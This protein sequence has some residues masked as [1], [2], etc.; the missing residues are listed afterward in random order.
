MDTIAD[1]LVYQVIFFN[2]L[3]F[4]N[5]SILLDIFNLVPMIGLDVALLLMSDLLHVLLHAILLR[6]GVLIALVP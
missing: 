3:L 2:L 6:L 5:L 1:K 4:R